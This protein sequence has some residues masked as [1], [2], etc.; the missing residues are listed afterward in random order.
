MTLIITVQ[1]V[2]DW[3]DAYVNF[4]Q[5]IDYNVKDTLEYWNNHLSIPAGLTQAEQIKF[6]ENTYFAD[7]LDLCQFANKQAVTTSDLINLGV[8]YIVADLFSVDAFIKPIAGK[9]ERIRLTLNKRIKDKAGST[10]AGAFSARVAKHFK[11]DN[12]PVTGKL[13][14]FVSSS[15]R[16]NFELLLDCCGVV[17]TPIVRSKLNIQNSSE[18]FVCNE[19]LKQRFDFMQKTNVVLT[20]KEQELYTF[21]SKGLPC[22]V[23]TYMYYLYAFGFIQ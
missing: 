11:V 15:V 21:A 19:W 17:G 14:T 7:Y 12:L 5:N 6:I 4:L 20:E 10:V 3:K 8:N 2:K 22:S 16:H 18:F 23:D 1:T 13:D 9:H